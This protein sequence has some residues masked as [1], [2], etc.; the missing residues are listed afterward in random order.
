MFF[1]TIEYLNF[2]LRAGNRHDVHS[3]FVYDLYTNLILDEHP[4]YVYEPIE[5]LRAGLL[6][7]H[8]KIRVSDFGTGGIRTKERELRIRYIASHFVKPAR[9]GQLLFRLVNRFQPDTILELGTS[10]GISTLYL[11][12][13]KKNARVFSLEGCEATASVARLN[14]S[15][16]NSMVSRMAVVSKRRSG[17]EA[18]KGSSPASSPQIKVKL[19]L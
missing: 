2:L 10:L 6:L 19:S 1:S 14:F 7:N 5:S 4:Y 15:K 9:F 16:M 11:A 13:P 8:E 18:C 17:F 12:S 3:P